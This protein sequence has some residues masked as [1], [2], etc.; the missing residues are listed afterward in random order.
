MGKNFK[1]RLEGVLF[2]PETHLK[3]QLKM[4]IY[5]LLDI[6]EKKEKLASL[7]YPNFHKSGLMPK[8]HEFYEKMG[9]LVNGR[10]EILFP[11]WVRGPFLHC[12]S[13]K[14]NG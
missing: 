3:T 1:G 12:G 13:S 2:Y 14:R 11:V 6:R 9:E 4:N 10:F 7:K 5:H 8:S